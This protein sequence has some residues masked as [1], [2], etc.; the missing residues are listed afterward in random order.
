MADTV[1][2]ERATRLAAIR[3]R[4]AAATPGP[5]CW[6]GNK[7]AKDIQLQSIPGVNGN[8]LLS[9]MTFWRWGMQSAMPG[10]RDERQVLRKPAWVIPQPWNDWLIGG[11]DHPDARFIEHSREDVEWLADELAAME[12]RCRSV[13][14]LLNTEIMPAFCE[15]CESVGMAAPEDNAAMLRA[16][17]ALL[18]LRVAGVFT[19]EELA[20]TEAP[21]G[22]R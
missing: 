12:E 19:G 3:E 9:V 7:S 18:A 13:A 20:A 14:I 21:G 11:I 1:S 6:R 4:V 15:L 8:R 22:G 16:Y 5:W 17:D 2:E 10:F